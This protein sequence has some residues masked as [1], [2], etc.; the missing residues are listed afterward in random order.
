M[1]EKKEKIRNKWKKRRKSSPRRRG[2]FSLIFILKHI[3]ILWQI[4]I[5]IS[6][7]KSFF[8]ILIFYL[9]Q[10]LQKI[11]IYPVCILIKDY[12]QIRSN[13]QIL[14]VDMEDLQARINKWMLMQYF[15]EFGCI[16]LSSFAFEAIL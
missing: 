5:L 15:S 1:R 8:L 6:K 3:Q 9:V 4:Q 11:W 14:G 12:C 7:G 16:F 2:K 10:P 13:L